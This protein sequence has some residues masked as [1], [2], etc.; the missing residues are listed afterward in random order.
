MNTMG[1]SD[2]YTSSTSKALGSWGLC[3]AYQ[4][5]PSTN[6]SLGKDARGRRFGNSISYCVFKDSRTD[7]VVGRVSG[8]VAQQ[9]SSMVHTRLN[10][11]G[12]RVSFVAGGTPSII[13]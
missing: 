9:R 11:L 5:V 2:S 7:C 8:V 13:S 12:I 10:S 1:R 3:K 4:S 6:S